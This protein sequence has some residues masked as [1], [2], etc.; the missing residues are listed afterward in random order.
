[1][2]EAA[3]RESKDN[4]R[5]IGALEVCPLKKV[6]WGED[7]ICNEVSAPSVL[8]VSVVRPTPCI[9]SP[10]PTPSLFLLLKVR[11]VEKGRKVFMMTAH[12]G[13]VSRCFC[14]EPLESQEDVDLEGMVMIP[15]LQ[16]DDDHASLFH[17]LLRVHSVTLPTRSLIVQWGYHRSNGLL[18]QSADS[19]CG[20][21][22]F[23]SNRITGLC[24]IFFSLNQVK[25]GLE[26]HVIRVSFLPACPMDLSQLSFYSE[27][28]LTLTTP[29]DDVQ[30]RS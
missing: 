11:G 1:M 17:A 15:E 26:S 30:G 29:L 12:Q 14:F 23:F 24:S 25:G 28:Q 20:V 5:G 13:V 9:A 2:M 21:L 27:R 8:V 16:G 10:P 22:N 6:L 18:P 7:L 3:V 4:R 19:G